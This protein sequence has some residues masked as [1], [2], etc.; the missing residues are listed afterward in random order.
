MWISFCSGFWIVS[1]FPINNIDFRNF[2]IGLEGGIPC[3]IYIESYFLVII[4]RY[5]SL[6]SRR[7]LEILL[8]FMYVLEVKVLNLH[9]WV[10]HPR[11]TNDSQQ[12]LEY[13][14]STVSLNPILSLLF[15]LLNHFV[16]MLLSRGSLPILNYS[17]LDSPP[18]MAFYLRV[19][20]WNLVLWLK[21]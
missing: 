8:I 10:K 9:R 13:L 12:S 6:V 16:F 7:I 14:H 3:E 17:Q 18:V 21:V 2:N 5:R 20:P 1:H 11:L 4:G 15:L 19:L